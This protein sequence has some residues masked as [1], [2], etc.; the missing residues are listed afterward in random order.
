MTTNQPTIPITNRFAWN[1][2]SLF[3]VVQ[4]RLQMLMFRLLCLF[5]DSH[6]WELVIP[7]NRKTSYLTKRHYVLLSANKLVCQFCGKESQDP[8]N[9]LTEIELSTYK[10]EVS[11]L[12]ERQNLVRNN[13]VFEN[14]KTQGSQNT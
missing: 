10:L 12:Y 14:E 6:S 8:E 3:E 4:Y 11:Y 1:R 9:D 7:E 13:A 5:I 2:F